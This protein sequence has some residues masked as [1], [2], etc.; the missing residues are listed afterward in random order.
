MSFN[1][2][3]E[4]LSRLTFVNQLRQESNNAKYAVVKLDAI[5]TFKILQHQP[6]SV[7]LRRLFY[8]ILVEFYE[9]AQKRSILQFV[10]F[11]HLS[12]H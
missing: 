4:T 8:E 2:T 7:G 12:I 3:W 9:N 1:V 6:F 5:R 11:C 10:S